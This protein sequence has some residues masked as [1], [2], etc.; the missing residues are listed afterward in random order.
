MGVFQKIRRLFVREK[1]EAKTQHIEIKTVSPQ[2][3]A[4]RRQ[5]KRID[6]RRG[7]RALIIDDSSTVV[8]VFKKYLTSAGYETYEALNAELGLE[9]ARA[10]KPELVFLDIILPG[11]DGFAA[12]R[13]IRRDPQTRHIPVIMISGNEQA[14]EQFYANRIGADSFMKKPFKRPDLF[15]QIE[16]LLDDHFVPRHVGHHP[17]A[18]L[19]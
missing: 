16:S 19:H 1:P 11:M 10:H 5:R 7:T 9:L 13:H 6:A 17:S 2:P 12:L 3:V 15:M 8:A 14:A 4:D 18:Q